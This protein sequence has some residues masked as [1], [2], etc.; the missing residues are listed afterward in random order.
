MTLDDTV[1]AMRKQGSRQSHVWWRV[2]KAMTSRSKKSR[3]C[4]SGAPRRGAGARRWMGEVGPCLTRARPG[5]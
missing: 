3:G 4:A 5:P 2:F 1:C